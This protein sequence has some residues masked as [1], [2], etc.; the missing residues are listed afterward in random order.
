MYTYYLCDDL[1][2]IYEINFSIRECDKEYFIALL[3][4]C[5]NETLL[6]ESHVEKR[7][8]TEDSIDAENKEL[9]TK[10]ENQIFL[11]R[12]RVIKKEKIE[13]YLPWIVTVKS[14]KYSFARNNTILF[15]VRLL[16]SVLDKVN[17]QLASQVSSLLNGRGYI[18]FNLIY[19]TFF[20]QDG[21]VSGELLSDYNSL[22]ELLKSLHLEIDMRYFYSY[23][24]NF[25]Q[26]DDA[27]RAVAEGIVEDSM[28][29][30]K[31]LKKLNIRLR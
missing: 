25:W 15:L 28:K 22:M 13:D 6:L 3:E 26:G 10:E 1:E 7:L 24:S 8:I 30:R 29:N 19:E 31:S 11:N 2:T 5:L 18:D 12:S 17:N 16:E 9:V 23:L 4:K 20:D 27:D 21:N 14:E